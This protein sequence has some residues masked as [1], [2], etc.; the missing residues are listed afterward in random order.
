MIITAVVLGN[1]HAHAL[2]LAKNIETVNDGCLT[3]LVNE[4]RVYC[5]L[6]RD[7]PDTQNPDDKEAVVNQILSEISFRNKFEEKLITLGCPFTFIEDCDTDEKLTLQD[8][9]ACDGANE[10][11]NKLYEVESLRSI[12]ALHNETYK[13]A[14][15][16]DALLPYVKKSIFTKG[17]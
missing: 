14:E 5:S 2:S 7:N 8:M 3:T 10:L 16:I 12:L 13:Y 4:N 1:S 17:N 9:K 6:S 15:A 11:L